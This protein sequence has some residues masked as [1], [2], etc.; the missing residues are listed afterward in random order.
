MNTNQTF[1]VVQFS[2]VGHTIRWKIEANVPHCF[3]D[4]RDIAPPTGSITSRI[5]LKAMSEQEAK[6]N[7]LLLLLSGKIKIHNFTIGGRYRCS[8]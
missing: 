1:D 8:S 3:E 2:R 5:Y 7:F 6:D 4:T